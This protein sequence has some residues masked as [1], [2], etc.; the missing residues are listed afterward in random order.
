MG[1]PDGPLWL[2]QDYFFKDDGKIPNS[3]Y[4]VLIYRDVHKRTGA[5]AAEWYEEQCP[6]LGIR[7]AD[8]IYRSIE[9]ISQRPEFYP[10]KRGE[11]REYV[12]ETFLFV[13]IFE[14]LRLVVRLLVFV[15]LKQLVP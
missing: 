8:L 10:K 12:V 3:K 7:F 11:Q 15:F 6:G 2:G 14:F 13:V 1:R 9:I 5:D 4:P